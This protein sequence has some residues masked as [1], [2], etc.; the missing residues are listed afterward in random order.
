[1]AESRCLKHQERVATARCAA[2]LKPL[3]DECALPTEEGTFCG[4]ECHQKRLAANQRVEQM[5][6]EEEAMKAWRFQ[7][8]LVSTAVWLLVIVGLAV[9]WPYIP[10]SITGPIE[11]MW[12][13]VTGK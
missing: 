4:F 12:A 9:G 1:M 10:D 8:K 3:C 2:C 13:S 7:R 11:A 6:A 5:Q